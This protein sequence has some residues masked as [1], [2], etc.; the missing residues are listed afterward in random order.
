[1]NEDVRLFSLVGAKVLAVR[2]GTLDL[3]GKSTVRTWTKLATTASNGTS[4]I[5]LMDAVD[6]PVNSEIIVAT[7]GDRFSQRESEVRR[8]ITISSDGRNLTMDR[9]LSYTHLGITRLVNA[10]AIEIRAEIGLLSHNIVF[11]G[12]ASESV[13]ETLPE[14][15]DGFNPGSDRTTK[16]AYI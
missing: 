2:D 4:E 11:G 7:T 6:W 16:Q 10:T 8:I 15:P 5:V 1:M 13:G 14:C 3:H 12:M 9:P